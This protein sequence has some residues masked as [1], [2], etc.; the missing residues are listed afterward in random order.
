VGRDRSIGLHPELVSR[1][2]QLRDRCASQGISI[3]LTQGLRTFEEQA[4]LYAQGR[5]APGK[6]VTNARPGDSLHNYGRAFD[7]AFRKPDGSVTWDGPWSKVGAIG[8]SLGLTW[9]GRWR[10]FPDR[11]HFQFLFAGESLATLKAAHAAKES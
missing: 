9:G 2:G 4:A 6:V 11:P 10:S 5:T 1:W 8:E 7:I 3:L